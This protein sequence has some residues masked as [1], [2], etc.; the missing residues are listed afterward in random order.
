MTSHFL[1]KG[2]LYSGTRQYFEK[3]VPGGYAALLYE[4]KRVNPALHDFM[5]QPF[6]DSVMYDVMWV[7]ELVSIEAKVTSKSVK[8]Y[9][10]HR[11]EWQANRDLSGAYKSLLRLATPEMALKAVPNLMVQM[12]NFGRPETK[13]WFTGY[14][15]VSFKGIPN[16]LEVWIMNAFKVYGHKVVDMAG[17]KV[18]DFHI[19]PPVS[20][21][22]LHGV[23]VSTLTVNLTYESKKT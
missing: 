1:A 9:L 17:G 3:E 2:T 14:H 6:L 8:A 16:V 10:V 11:T 4:I 15:V 5:S 20:E 21:G 7:P 23:P 19:D 18:T 12:F 13:K 22:V